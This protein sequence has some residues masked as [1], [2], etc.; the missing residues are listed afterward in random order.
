MKMTDE[1][2]MITIGGKEYDYVELEDNEQYLVNQI[3]D[4]NT[5]IAQAQFGMDQL[6]A[7]QDTFTKMLVESVNKP[8]TEEGDAGEA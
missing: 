7:A 6:R 8:E 4:L 1:K 3:R 5:K 2:Q